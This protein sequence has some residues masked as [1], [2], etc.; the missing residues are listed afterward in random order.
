[1]FGSYG[2]PSS[3]IAPLDKL[4]WASTHLKLNGTGTIEMDV[5]G[6]ST[7]QVFSEGPPAGQVWFVYSLSFLIVD[8]GTMDDDNFGVEPALANGSLSCNKINRKTLSRL[9]IG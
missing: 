7:Q 8:N 3:R 9:D 5:N 1:M 6:S 2:S 4:V